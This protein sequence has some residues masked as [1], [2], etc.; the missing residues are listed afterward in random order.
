MGYSRLSAGWS[1]VRVPAF[2]LFQKRPDLLCG[3]LQP[4]THWIPGFFPGLTWPGHEVDNSLRLGSASR[5]SGAILLRPL[6]AFMVW[7]GTTLPFFTF[8]RKNLRISTRLHEATIKSNGSF[9]LCVCVC[10]CVCVCCKTLI[11]FLPSFYC[12]CFL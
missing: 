2:F 12:Y 11:F 3:P 7:T 4:T 1:G 6:Y 5:M 9:F 8:P 10:V